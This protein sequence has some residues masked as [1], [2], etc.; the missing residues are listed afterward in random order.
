[1][2]KP[3]TGTLKRLP[4]G[5]LK[6]RITVRD[7][8]GKVRRPWVTLPATLTD[9]QARAAAIEVSAE[10][11]G[12]I[13]NPASLQ[14]LANLGPSPTVEDFV[15]K[16]WFPSREGKIKSMRQDRSHWKH[17]LGPLIGHLKMN[18]V[19]SEHL[20]A[21]VETLDDK[22]ANDDGIDGRTFGEKSALN[23]WATC[24]A[25]FR[26]ASSSKRREIR[27]LA[28]NPAKDLLPPDGP[29][30]IE[31]QW[32]YPSELHQ[33]LACP[34]VP[35]S[36][37]RLY[38]ACVYLFC[39]AGEVQ[40]LLWGQ[41]VDLEHGVVRINRAF[42]AETRGFNESTKT[43]DVRRFAIEPNLLA[44]FEQMA[45]EAEPGAELVFP[46]L[47]QLAE[48]LR[49]DLWAAGVRRESLHVKRKGSRIMRFHDLR[50]TGITYLALRGDTD[51][52]VRDRAGHTNFKTTLEYIRRG[53][54]V[55]GAKLGD[56]F[57]PLPA[58]LLE[59]ESSPIV[60]SSSGNGGESGE[61]PRD[62]NR[63]A[64]RDLLEDARKQSLMGAPW[65]RPGILEKPR[66]DSETIQYEREAF[67]I[68]LLE[69][70]GAHPPARP[71]TKTRPVGY[72][73]RKRVSL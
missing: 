29:S 39:R 33:L 54:H 18:E 14:R 57:G 67:A 55:I 47:W 34:L 59:R 61:S 11:Q 37:R 44:L 46:A 3:K 38:A 49:Q 32:L 19:T 40:A 17:H 50:A 9:E 31:K 72:V 45:R 71:L 16:V 70:P 63:P 26:D 15:Q 5:S 48:L 20:R 68:A 6:A 7:A 4:D 65:T 64:L 12:Q 10:A 66:D 69:H 53:Q 1:M 62:D 35:L 25:L 30:A 2:A 36:R 60:R 58:V 24:C 21:V 73:A 52:E 27:I 41:S 56:P 51:H 8:L 13:Y 23:V 42:N 43:G 22:A 28:V